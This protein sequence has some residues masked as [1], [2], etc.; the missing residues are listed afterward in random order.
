MVW[1]WTLF[2]CNLLHSYK[3]TRTLRSSGEH[4]HLLLSTM[5]KIKAFCICA[6]HCP[7]IY[8][9]ITDDILRTFSFNQLT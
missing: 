9:K 1:N 3:P 6:T 5:A 4:L 2:Q 8:L 7:I